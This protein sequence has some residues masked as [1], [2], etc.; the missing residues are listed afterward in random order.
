MHSRFGFAR[1]QQFLGSAWS[2]LRTR[3]LPIAH[4][5]LL[6]A[7]CLASAGFGDCDDY[8]DSWSNY[9]AAW[10]LYVD[11]APASCAEAGVEWV[12]VTWI[13][14]G[15]AASSQAAQCGLGSDVFGSEPGVPIDFEISLYDINDNVVG[16][17]TYES[18][19]PGRI[20]VPFDL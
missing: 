2:H 3:R 8:E 16:V 1:A 13:R 10:V 17:A 7:A 12:H 11:G 4:G 6:I 9:E 15:Q 14:N 5:P 20:E 19:A 18:V